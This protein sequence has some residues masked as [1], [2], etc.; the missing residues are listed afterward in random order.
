MRLKVIFYISI[1]IFLSSILS[2]CGSDNNGGD[3]PILGDCSAGPYISSIN[4][5]SISFN[6]QQDLIDFAE[7][8]HTS[9]TGSLD[10]YNGVSDLSP[11]NC[12]ES[13]WQL[14]I[15]SEDLTSFEGLENLKS[16]N[17][18]YVVGCHGIQNFQ[19]LNGLEKIDELYI[20]GNDQLINF[21]GLNSLESIYHMVVSSNIELVNFN[22]LESVVITP[23]TSVNSS[24]SSELSV[25]FNPN[26]TSISALNNINGYMFELG[27]SGNP[28]LTDLGVFENVTRVANI[29]IYSCNSLIN[30]S[31]FPN[32]EETFVLEIADCE[33]LET[34][35]L[36]SLNRMGILGI[37]NNPNF[38]SLE[39]F[40]ALTEIENPYTDDGRSIYLSGLFS[41][42]SL[43]GLEALQTTNHRVD[44]NGIASLTNLCALSNLVT[45]YLAQGTNYPYENHIS[46]SSLCG[47]SLDF[48]LNFENSCNC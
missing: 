31:C 7:S 34:I 37:Y 24:V 48:L 2:S 26:L 36:P 3:N 13:V 29:I 16:V 4:N 14:N 20:N 30:I 12:L 33:N 46:I 35:N 22:G 21:E 18:L 19:G 8:G 10:I 15:R 32:V 5:N 27:L 43:D 28:L 47:G 17:K 23:E 39:G 25:N 9:I 11:L 41:L 40:S 42:T 44:I 6:N 45:N 38:N 1:S